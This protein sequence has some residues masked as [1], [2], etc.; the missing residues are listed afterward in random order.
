MFVK[1][2]TL[3]DGNVTV[4]NK[5]YNFKNFIAEIDEKHKDVFVNVLHCIEITEQDAKK[6][7]QETKSE[8]SKK[9]QEAKAEDKMQEKK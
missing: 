6:I 7:L 1:H 5:T 9:K 2:P 4:E 3:K 8:V